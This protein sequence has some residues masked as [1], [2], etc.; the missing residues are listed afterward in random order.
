M[1]GWSAPATAPNWGAPAQ[2]A[3]PANSWGD[4]AQTPARQAPPSNS[5]GTSDM[6]AALP[7]VSAPANPTPTAETTEGVK[8]PQDHGWTTK[9]PYD[10]NSYNK[11]NKEY[12]EERAAANAGAAEGAAAEGVTPLGINNDFTEIGWAS[13]AALYNF[14]EGDLGEIGPEHHELEKILF[15][16]EFQVRSGIKFDR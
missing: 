13:D 3:D 7:D 6:A 14:P 1:S 16:S 12:D 2:P 10:Y 11:S 15:G 5:W 4:L 8:N 9:Q